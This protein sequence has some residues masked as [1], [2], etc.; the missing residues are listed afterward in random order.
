[1]CVGIMTRAGGIQG[2]VDLIRKYAKGPISSQICSF[3]IG[4]LIFFDDYSNCVITGTTM[5]PLTDHNRVSREKLSYI[6]DSTE[7]PVAGIS[8][9]STWVAYEVSTFAPQL[10]E[11]THSDGT[12]YQQSEGFSVFVAT[13]PFRFYCIFMLAMVASMRQ[14]WFAVTHDILMQ[15]FLLIMVAPLWM[16]W[17]LWAWRPKAPRGGAVV[18]G[19]RV[20]AP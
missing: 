7:A 18:G 1:M 10:P 12:P 19:N 2:M 17:L 16:A 13:L 11:V 20:P 9:F 4:V 8:I 5:R 14:E 3:L 6:V 15:G